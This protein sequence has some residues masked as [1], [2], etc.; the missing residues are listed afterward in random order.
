MENSEKSELERMVLAPYIQ[1]STALRGKYRFVGGN[2][3]RHALGT[4][5]ILL[6][7]HY[8]DPVL[9]KASIIHDVF[10]DS[11]DVRPDEIVYLDSD[12]PEVY[13][14]VMEVTRTINES[15]DQYL[16]RVLTK[17][18]KKAK[19]LKCA[20]RISNLTDLHPDIFDRQFVLRYIEETKKWVIPMAMEVNENMLI[21]LKDLINRR[22]ANMETMGHVWPLPR[23]DS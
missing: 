14:L 17:G 2:Q 16:E 1:K 21:E 23:K 15:K 18:S 5:A 8:M 10:E 22:E 9:L 3:F 11:N 12:G 7:Y 4:F 6:D 19:I 13:K 20:D